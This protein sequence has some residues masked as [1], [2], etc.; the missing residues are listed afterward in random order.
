MSDEDVAA[1]RPQGRIVEHLCDHPGCKNKGA[2][3]YAH[4]RVAPNW[5]RFGHRIEWPPAKKS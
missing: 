4:G 1:K 2:F 5:Y 3:G